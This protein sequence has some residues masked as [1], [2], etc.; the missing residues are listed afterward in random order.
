MAVYRKPMNSILITLLFFLCCFG[1][2]R[3]GIYARGKTPEHHFGDDSRDIVIASAGLVATLT[4]LILGLL[5]A[6]ASANFQL[7]N[8]SLEKMGTEVLVLDRAMESYGPETQEARETL[9]QH[10]IKIVQAIWPEDIPKLARLG[11]TASIDNASMQPKRKSSEPEEPLA[12]RTVNL[13]TQIQNQLLKLS[14]KDDRQRWWQTKA[15][16]AG[17]NLIEEQWLIAEQAKSPVPT[18]FLIFLA[19]WLIILF[20]SFSLFSPPYKAVHIILIFCAISVASSLFLILELNKPSSGLLK[21]SSEP[22]RKV[23]FLLDQ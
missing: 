2:I 15:L 3:L 1:G 19:V 5:V 8:A 13:L 6:S 10:L 18:P 11:I 12:L 23:I 4:A 20:S 14:P 9:R 16:D 17:D 22:L 7:Y 21:V